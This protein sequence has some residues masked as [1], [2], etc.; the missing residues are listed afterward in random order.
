MKIST[1]LWLG[2][3]VATLLLGAVAVV[4]G[5]ADAPVERLVDG[6][7]AWWRRVKAAHTQVL[8]CRRAEKDL[9]LFRDDKYAVRQTPRARRSAS[10]CRTC[11]RAA[12]PPSRASA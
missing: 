8:Q 4:G 5:G 2:C 6:D 9:L 3:A 10:C 11:S 12:R 1:R 7:L